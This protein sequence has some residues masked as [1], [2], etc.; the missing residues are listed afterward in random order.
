[1]ATMQ[2]VAALGFVILAALVAPG[3]GGGS[4]PSSSGSVDGEVPATTARHAGKPFAVRRSD[5]YD[6]GCQQVVGRGPIRDSEPLSA[7]PITF[8]GAG[9]F[10]VRRERSVFKR[11][12]W[13][14]FKAVTE[15]LP[16]KSA[17]LATRPSQRGAF[18]VLYDPRNFRSPG[19]YR[20]SDGSAGVR[21]GTCGDPPAGQVRAFTGGFLAKRPGCFA[22]SAQTT[23][24]P[25][26]RTTV[27]IGMGTGRCRG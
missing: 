2:R 16:G 15:V 25:A 23:G 17:V 18:L 19:Q 11:G 3:C 24:E 4:T 6:A 14:A 12:R 22:V 26:E 13:S 5:L 20:Q 8:H 7:G 27:N 9:E 1:M 21:F 10:A